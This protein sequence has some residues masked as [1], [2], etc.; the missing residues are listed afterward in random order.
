MWL[1]TMQIYIF[2]FCCFVPC[3][4]EV[5]RFSDT[6][7]FMLME[8]GHH[9]YAIGIAFCGGILFFAFQFRVIDGIEV[10]IIQMIKIHLNYTYFDCNFVYKKFFFLFCFCIC[11]DLAGKFCIFILRSNR[12]KDG[13]LLHA[14]NYFIGSSRNLFKNLFCWKLHIYVIFCFFF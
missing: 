4:W 1:H 7:R 11:F 14:M 10:T 12:R 9:L 2:V 5:L 3:N 13:A 6:F 8:W